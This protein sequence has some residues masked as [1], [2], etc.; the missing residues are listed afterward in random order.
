MNKYKALIIEDEINNAAILKHFL[1][2]YCLN[3]EVIGHASSVQEAILTINAQQPDILFID[4]QLN[5][6]D[7][8]DILDSFEDIKTQ[9]IFVTSHDEY[10]VKAFK[11]N[12]I[13][14]ILKPIVIEDII[15]AVNKAIK[16]IERQNYFDF[17]KLSTFAGTKQQS[18]DSNEYIAIASIDKIDL[19]KVNEI[20]YIKADDK[21]TIFHTI[22]AKK[23]TSTKNLLHFE[24]LIEAN[25]FF[26]VHHSYIINIEHVV[27]ILKKDG[28]YCELVNG[29]L[30]PI[31][32]RKLDDFNRFLKIKN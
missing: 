4:I 26:R 20:L 22:G 21:Y 19:L 30:I 27:R 32:K 17:K 24:K 10:A 28:S 18:F 7:A 9:I 12:A 14:Y 8:F 2:K 23:Y 29:A 11:Y 16:N 25:R 6:G 15:L 31:S 13:D 1:T 3:I 5:E